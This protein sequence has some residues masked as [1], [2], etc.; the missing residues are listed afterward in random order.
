MPALLG[1]QCGRVR[2]AGIL[3]AVSK[4]SGRDCRQ[5]EAR[6]ESLCKARE[7]ARAQRRRESLGIDASGSEL[8]AP[9]LRVPGFG[10]R[11]L[12]EKIL[13]GRVDLGRG[14][15]RVQRRAVQLFPEVLLVACDVRSHRSP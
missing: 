13:A 14:Q 5:H 9:Q 3:I 10:L 11:Q 6:T 15:C 1:R 12:Q 8:L 2:L 7:D 4:L